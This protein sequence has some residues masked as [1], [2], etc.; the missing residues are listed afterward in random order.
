MLMMMGMCGGD[1]EIE[2]WCTRVTAANTIESKVSGDVDDDGEAHHGRSMMRAD[3]CNKCDGTDV[4]G[5][6]VHST[7]L[8][9]PP[10]EPVHRPQ[11]PQ[12]LQLDVLGACRCD[13]DAGC[14]SK[15]PR[16]MSEREQKCSVHGE[17]DDLTCEAPGKPCAMLH[18]PRIPSVRT[19][20]CRQQD[21]TRLRLA[22]LL[23]YKL[24]STISIHNEIMTGSEKPK[25]D[26][27]Y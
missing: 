21:H 5:V 3:E 27:Y 25:R 8:P 1:K 23:R 22:T 12:S 6:P 10:D 15:Q 7:D 26:E 20:T 2:I 9:L 16:H 4:D 24:N 11:G 14:M 19:G 13:E 18:R 17:E